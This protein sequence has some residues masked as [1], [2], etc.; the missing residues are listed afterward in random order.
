MSRSGLEE[1]AERWIPGSG[2]VVVRP[3]T[4][5]LVNTSCRVERDGQVYALRVAAA[6]AADLGL[7]R[8]WECRVLSRAAAAGLAP[9]VKRCLPGPGIVV[10]EWLS[11]RAW[12]AA[13]ARG[14]VALA[15]VAALLRRVHALPIPRPARVMNPAGWIA[16]YSRVT[17]RGD[18]GHA[19]AGMDL[20]V[21]AAL[22]LRQLR[23]LASP[24]P[25]LCHSDVHRLNILSDAA[26]GR[27]VLLDWEY[28]HVAD[29]LWDVAGWVMNNDLTTVE[30]SRLLEAYLLR[31][32]EPAEGQRL[33]LL[34]WLYGYVCL[35]WS[36]IYA[37]QRTGGDAAAVAA[38][39]ATLATRLTR[40]AGGRAG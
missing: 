33:Q 27:L 39:A 31:T 38:R 11:G 9:P 30:A 7:D 29:G 22:R 32:P 36:G 5:G 3:L 24:A 23:A 8:A 16:H 35:L 40:S 34:V 28:A 19:P 10:A 18:C 6:G 1:I 4:A 25:V 14:A 17:A 13:E 2:V 12:S 26:G 37:Q 15:A 21:P 20:R